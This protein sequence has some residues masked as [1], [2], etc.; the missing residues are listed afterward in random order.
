MALGVGSAQTHRSD[1]AHR[2]QYPRTHAHAATA[3]KISYTFHG[4]APWWSLPHVRP[5]PSVMPHL[6][7]PSRAVAR[8]HQ[9]RVQLPQPRHG[10]G[11]APLHA[12]AGQVQAC[13]GWG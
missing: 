12:A 3:S 10:V 4:M 5:L 13:A 2:L 7:P 8:H 6:R 11:Y 1:A 9:V